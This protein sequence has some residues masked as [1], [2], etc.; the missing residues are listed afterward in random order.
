LAIGADVEV[1]LES[2]FDGGEGEPLV[3]LAL[4]DFF[5]E[6]FGLFGEDADMG[7]A[8]AVASLVSLVADLWEEVVAGSCLY[9]FLPLV[10]RVDLL[11]FGVCALA[12]AAVVL[13]VSLALGS[14]LVAVAEAEGG[15]G[16]GGGGAVCPSLGAPEAAAPPPRP[17]DRVLAMDQ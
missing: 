9:L 6:S 4:A 10:S 7:V 17:P 11:R 13:L 1:P 2:W 15:G 5:V 16:G 12:V 8:M 14:F 3:F